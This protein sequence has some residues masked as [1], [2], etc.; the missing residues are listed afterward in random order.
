[1][2]VT[3]PV[4]TAAIHLRKNTSSTISLFDQIPARSEDRAGRIGDMV[5]FLMIGPVKS[6]KRGDARPRGGCWSIALSKTQP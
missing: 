6:V 2:Q 4:K 3:P 1:M 5:N